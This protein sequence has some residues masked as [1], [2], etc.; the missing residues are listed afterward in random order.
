MAR[1]VFASEVRILQRLCE[2]VIGI[3]FL[4]F[5]LF[6]IFL[7]FKIHFGGLGGRG[8]VPPGLLRA[9]CCHTEGIP[10]LKTDSS[11]IKDTA[12]QLPGTTFLVATPQ[13]LLLVLFFSLAAAAGG[14]CHSP[15]FQFH[16]ASLS[17]SSH[18]VTWLW[19][20]SICWQLQNFCLWPRPLSWS[21]TLNLCRK[22]LP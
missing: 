19:I 18:Q 20:P 3:H 10:K 14:F 15:S 16:L 8:E 7:I 2:F 17:W 9:C 1:R 21:Q 12:P 22:V 4:I 6:I 13:P 11:A 5:I